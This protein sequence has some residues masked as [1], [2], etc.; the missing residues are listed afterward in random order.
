MQTKVNHS[1]RHIYKFICYDIELRDGDILADIEDLKV[2]LKVN[3][4]NHFESLDDNFKG[5]RFTS[6]QLQPVSSV[7]QSMEIVVPRKV[8]E[9]VVGAKIG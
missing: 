7:I 2:G 6:Y 3:K 4:E 1:F 9:E 8:L 5:K